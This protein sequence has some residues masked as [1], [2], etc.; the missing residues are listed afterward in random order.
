MGD[1]WVQARTFGPEGPD[2]FAGNVESVTGALPGG[3]DVRP[4]DWVRFE[5]RHVLS[6]C[7]SPG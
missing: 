7:V 1:A 4:D 3:A 5:P 2:A 6:A